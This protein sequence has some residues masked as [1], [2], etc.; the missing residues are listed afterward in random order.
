MSYAC[1]IL[2]ASLVSPKSSLVVMFHTSCIP[3]LQGL[4]NAPSAPNHACMT[5]KM[6]LHNHEDTC[7]PV[8]ACHTVQELSPYRIHEKCTCKAAFNASEGT[9]QERF[10]CS[11]QYCLAPATGQSTQ[12]RGAH[13]NTPTLAQARTE[14]DS[15]QDN[16]ITNIA[17]VYKEGQAFCSVL[18]ISLHLNMSSKT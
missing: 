8:L 14:H 3:L 2:R 12:K 1:N 7:V 13:M 18:P 9:T 4:S 6:F 5:M 17:E 10:S 11:A 16:V 15:R